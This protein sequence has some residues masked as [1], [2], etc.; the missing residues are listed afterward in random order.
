MRGLRLF[1]P[2]LVLGFSCGALTPPR[3]DGGTATGGGGGIATGGGAQTG[4]GSQ[5]GG[6][7]GGGV[8]GGGGG[9]AEAPWTEVALQVPTGTLGTVQRLSARPGEIY[10]L[11]SNQYLLR[12]AGGTFTEVIVFFMPVI[13]DFQL[14]ATGAVALTPAA[15]LMSCTTNCEG[16]TGYG[17][18]G[19]GA[20]PIA[21]C[22]SADWLGVMT[23]TPD[24]GAAL[25]E[26][27][28]NGAQ[29]DFV[30]KLNLRS[31]LD[32]ART[33]RGEIF[34][35][36]Q[37]G[38]GS[39][40]VTAT[41]VEV[42]STTSLGRVSTNEPWTK[43][44]TD[45]TWVIASSAR[46][47]VARRPEDGG[48]QVD[49]ALSGE[50]SAPAV[51]SATELWVAGTGLGLSRFDGTRWSPAGVGPSQ[52]TSF[53]ALAVESSYVYMGGRDAAGVARVFRRLR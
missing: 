45:G 27:N 19:L 28:P 32:C 53:D 38:V 9:G 3:P 6:G 43:V 40:T 29:W 18:F 35:A 17:D 33:T 30:T 41:S 42:P 47:A 49:S 8:T 50:I 22:G 21:V 10:A 39:A 26:Q 12:S 1:I 20:T 15:R 2:L 36:G 52:L 7:T 31:P 11:V 51:E 14:S 34:V 5:T 44:A 16:G 25:Y 24:A 23:R 46:G 4:G 48:W 37:G 13:S